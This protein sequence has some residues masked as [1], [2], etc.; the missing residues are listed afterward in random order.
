MEIVSSKDYFVITTN[1]DGQFR[2]AEV[3]KSRFFEVQGNYAYFQCEN[4]CHDKFYYNEEIQVWDTTLQ[5]L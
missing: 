1:V 4:A 5:G 2:K 3:E